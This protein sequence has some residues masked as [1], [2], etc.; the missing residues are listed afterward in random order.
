MLRPVLVRR[1]EQPTFEYP[2]FAHCLVRYL[3]VSHLFLHNRLELL[4]FAHPNE[5]NWPD[6]R[7]DHLEVRPNYRQPKAD[8]PAPVSNCSFAAKYI[9]YDF[10]PFGYPV[11]V[12]YPFPTRIPD[13]NRVNQTVSYICLR[14]GQRALQLPLR[15]RT[16]GRSYLQKKAPVKRGHTDE[17][18]AQ[19][20]GPSLAV[21]SGLSSMPAARRCCS[22]IA[23]IICFLK[24]S[25]LTPWQLMLIETLFAM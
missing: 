15:N 1:S 8:E 21:S 24:Y 2:S 5:M 14:I 25:S 13:S 3:T 18:W 7:G 4:D 12:A 11:A 19:R 9:S 6:L 20:R 22:A 23:C 16:R 10:S 17:P